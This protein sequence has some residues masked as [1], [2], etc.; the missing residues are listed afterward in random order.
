LA[1]VSSF[2]L[3]PTPFGIRPRQCVHKV[4]SDVFLQPVDGGV[5]VR[6]V[7]GTVV[8]LPALQ[9]CIDWDEKMQAI[10][11]ERRKGNSTMKLPGD[12][13]LD[14]AGYYPPGYVAT[15]I[16]NYQVRISTS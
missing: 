15:F 14:N 12:G 3:I 8:F 9:E 2:D 11:A 1:V 4:E 7:N 16:G 13:W 10:R 6:H 5:E